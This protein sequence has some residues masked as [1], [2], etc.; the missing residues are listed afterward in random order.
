MVRGF[1]L[2]LRYGFYR[3]S[4]HKCAAQTWFAFY[5]NASSVFFDK[6]LAQNKPQAGSFLV[7]GSLGDYFLTYIK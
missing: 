4:K 1:L 3:Q 2:R 5:M 6:I 7:V